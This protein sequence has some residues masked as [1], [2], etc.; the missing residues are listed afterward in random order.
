MKKKK[1]KQI[2]KTNTLHRDSIAA[3]LGCGWFHPHCRHMIHI[4]PD[5]ALERCSERGKPEI[6]RPWPWL[7]LRMPAVIGVTLLSCHFWPESD[8]E[9]SFFS[10]SLYMLP[11]SP[12]DR[13]S[14]RQFFLESQSAERWIAAARP[15][16]G[17]ASLCRSRSLCTACR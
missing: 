16:A 14:S 17:P 15:R 12:Q 2:T 8:R 6:R 11:I 13:L 10:G 3:L 7:H 4:H 9:T 1:T 5:L